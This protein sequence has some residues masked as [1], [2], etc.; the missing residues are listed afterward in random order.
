MV[1]LS[2]ESTTERTITKRSLLQGN[3]STPI[4]SYQHTCI[5]RFNC[6]NVPALCL[7]YSPRYSLGMRNRFLSSGPRRRKTISCF[8]HAAN[9]LEPSAAP[10]S[11]V[12]KNEN[13]LESLGGIMVNGAPG[14][15]LEYSMYSLGRRLK[16]SAAKPRGLRPLGFAASGLPSDKIPREPSPCPLAQCRHPRHSP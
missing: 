13:L 8:R 1:S 6:V 7:V 11:L 12:R 10:R 4:L 15:F 16:A 9:S 2:V 5:L 3:N 14:S